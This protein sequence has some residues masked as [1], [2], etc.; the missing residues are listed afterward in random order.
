[1]EEENMLKLKGEEK[2]EKGEKGEIF[3]SKKASLESRMEE[4]QRVKKKYPNGVPVVL[5]RMADS[6]IAEIDKKKFVVTKT[7]QVCQFMG[8]VRGRLSLRPDQAIFLF[9]NGRIPGMTDTMGSLY[10]KYGDEDGFLYV[11]YCGESVYGGLLFD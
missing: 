2:G 4:A 10:E 9:I 7:V 8:V 3:E 11:T 6:N 5:G 1:M